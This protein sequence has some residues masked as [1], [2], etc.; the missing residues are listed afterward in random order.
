MKSTDK[1]DAK[2][3]GAAR[4]LMVHTYLSPEEKRRVGE[5]AAQ[6]RLPVSAFLRRLALNVTLPHPMDFAAHQAVLS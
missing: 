3:A 5:K 6:L 1:N 4:S 2:E